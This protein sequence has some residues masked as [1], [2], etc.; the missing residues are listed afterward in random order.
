[1][2][3]V[4]TSVWVDFLNGRRCR[5]TDL[6]D[7]LLTGEFVLTGDLIVAEVLQGIRTDADYRRTLDAMNGLPFTDMLG[8]DIAVSS[9]AHYRTLRK[10]GV[11]IR[12]TIDVMI[13]TFCVHN[14]LPLLHNDRDFDAMAAHIGL[15]TL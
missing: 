5:Q 4:D 11:T 14:G 8:R 7:D 13:A 10:N 1:M 9:A 12:K 3:V 15:R 6:L 2:V